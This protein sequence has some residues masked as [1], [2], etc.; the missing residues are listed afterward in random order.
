MNRLVEA[1]S[2][3]LVAKMDDD[4]LYGAQ[5][6]SDQAFALAYSGADVVG[7]QAHYLRLKGPDATLLRFR[8][9]EH[10]YT[11]FVMG[12]TIVARRDLA[13]T[14]GFPAVARGEDTGFLRAAV[15]AGARIYS[16]D[17]FNF[18]QV[19]RPVADGHTWAMSEAELLASGDVVAFGDFS[20]HV[21]V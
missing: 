11:D 9:R 2:G 18:L 4:D 8:E 19:R 16:A 10:R 12:P 14:T 3:H 5:Y 17:R 13:A 20:Q 6:L 21:M 15:D 1:A 7:K